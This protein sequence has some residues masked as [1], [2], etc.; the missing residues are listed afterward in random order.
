[1]DLKRYNNLLTSGRWYNKNPKDAHILALVR[2]YQ[3]LADDSKKSSEKYNKDPTKGEPSYIRD[4]PPWI[5][6]DP[7]GGAGKKPRTEKNIGGA[8]STAL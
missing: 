5:L 6:E 7:K 2:V 8:R 4:L 1:M 3:K